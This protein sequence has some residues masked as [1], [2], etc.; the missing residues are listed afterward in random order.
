M[1]HLLVT[2][3][4][5]PK[6]G[7]IQSY[8]WE[9]WRRLPSQDVTIL[10]TPYDGDLAFDGDQHFRV[11]RTKQK[12][13][14]PTPALRRQINELADEVAADFIVIDPAFPLGVIGPHLNRPYVVVGHGAEFTIPAQMP[15]TK[16]LIRRV[17]NNA[18]GMVAGGGWVERS[19]RASI[20]SG[21]EVSCVNVP[22]GV[23]TKRFVVASHVE[24]ARAKQVLGIAPDA[25]VV[26]GISR[27][28]PRKGFDRLI[29]ASSTLARDSPNLRVLIAG[30]GRMRRSLQRLVARTGAPA[31]LLGRVSDDVLM[32]LHAAADVF[33]M[34]CHDRWFGLEQEGF[35]IVFVEAAASGVP[36]LAGASG[37]SVDAVVN[38]TTGYVLENVTAD[39]AA[40]VLRRMINDAEGR[41]AMGERARR[42]AVEEL[43]YDVLAGTLAG[44]FRIVQE[45]AGRQRFLGSVKSQSQGVRK[46]T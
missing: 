3:D 20:N 46:L 4:F 1:G 32:T 26:I 5:P 34:P 45:T 29:R 11:V 21:A 39:N 16:H 31:T 30:S 10:T 36:S 40:S 24:K 6:I 7:G 27:L 44:F 19:M 9:L 13:L 12:W 42:R 43:D 35:G 22:P 28:V 15:V 18:I 17:T 8:I 41:L 25:V 23:D 2:N 14:L 38:G 33:C 37:G